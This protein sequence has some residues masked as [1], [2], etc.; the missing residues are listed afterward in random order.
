MQEEHE[1]LP[2]HQLVMLVAFFITIAAAGTAGLTLPFPPLWLLALVG[3]GASLVSARGHMRIRPGGSGS[4][5]IAPAGTPT[6]GGSVLVPLWVVGL[7]GA[8]VFTAPKH[9]TPQPATRS[10]RG[11]RQSWTP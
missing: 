3:I 1:Y 8:G 2:I 11:G 10:F 7:R 4:A 5:G 9:L 6:L